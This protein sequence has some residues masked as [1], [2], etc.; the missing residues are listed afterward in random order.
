LSYAGTYGADETCPHDT[1]WKSCAYCSTLGPKP[2][3]QQI[4]DLR[5][6]QVERKKAYLQH[7]DAVRS[8]LGIERVIVVYD[9]SCPSMDCGWSRSNVSRE[10]LDKAIQTHLEFAQHVAMTWANVNPEDAYVEP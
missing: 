1:Y 6:H 2:T 4:A 5:A 9:A 10:E 3:R 8:I 7:P